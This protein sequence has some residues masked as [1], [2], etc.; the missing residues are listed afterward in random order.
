MQLLW[1][2]PFLQRLNIELPYD[3]PIPL[4][5]MCPRETKAYTHTK[6]CTQMF[7][8]ALFMPKTGTIQCPLSDKWID[9]M[10]S[11]H[12]IEYYSAMKRNGIFTQATT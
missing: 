8:A 6:M 10:W 3:L 4:L 9:T 12:T 11:I 5:G 2:Q 7:T 1:K